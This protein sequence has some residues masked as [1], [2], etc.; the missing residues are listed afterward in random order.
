[1]NRFDAS[2]NEIDRST[3]RPFSH[4]HPDGVWIIA[5]I[6]SL[7]IVGTIASAVVTLIYTADSR[8]NAKL[9]GPTLVIGALYVP[10]LVFLFRRSKIGFF[11]MLVLAVLFAVGGIVAALK[12]NG[13]GQLGT[14]ALVGIAIGVAQQAYIAFYTYGLKRDSLLR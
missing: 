6:Y 12:L 4:G 14:S 13:E 1:M 2:F 11:W 5:I 10:P 9:I 7:L 8:L 3:G